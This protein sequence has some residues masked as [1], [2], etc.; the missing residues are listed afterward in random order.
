MKI[1]LLIIDPQNDFCVPDDGHGNAGTLCIPGAHDD[2]KRVA[3]MIDRIGLKLDDIH[4][5]L[6]SHRHV[7]ISHPIWWKDS[8]GV[9]PPPFT[10]LGIDGEKIV[11]LE[12]QPNSPPI[13]TGQEY[14]TYLPSFLKRSKE[15]LRAL[16]A[17]GRYPHCIWPDHCLI[18]TWG[19]NVVPELMASLL[20]WEDQFATV[21]YVTKGSNIWT[22][23]F[24]AVKAEVPDPEDPTTQINTNFIQTL[25]EADMIVIAG[26]ARSHCLANTVV[27]IANAFSDTAYVKKMVLL[28]DCS[29]DVPSFEHYGE[30]FVKD[31]S[32]RGM[33]TSTTVDFL[34]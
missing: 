27:D 21:D 1:H 7:D 20:R 24:S 23:H 11:K 9:P 33:Q 34:K 30:K 29:S 8:K 10:L 2:M 3:A 4:V 14:T 5:T 19:H 13:V 22:E 6:D 28:K 31:M 17:G 16:T 25:E 18:G 26:E 12:P 15:Y 32:A